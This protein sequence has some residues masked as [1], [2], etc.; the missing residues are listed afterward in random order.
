MDIG[1]LPAG[2]YNYT[3]NTSWSGEKYADSGRLVVRDIQFELYDQEARHALLYS[4]AERTGGTVT[5]PN[6][7]L[8]LGTDLLSSD[9]IKPVIY[10]STITKPL[11]D[12]KWFI[13]LLII[14]LLLE[15]A[16]RRYFGSL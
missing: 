2:T 6:D 16:L 10:Q 15:W 9:K 1:R 3:A 8:A 7:I 12:N 13:L 11:M 4:L 14:P 5:Y